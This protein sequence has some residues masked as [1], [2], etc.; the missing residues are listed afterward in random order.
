[1][2]APSA[3]ARAALAA[4]LLAGPALAGLAGVPLPATSS[5]W[6]ADPAR[7]VEG[8]GDVPVMPGLAPAE[9]APLVFDK[10]A[11]R[12]AQSVMAG[13]M[14]RNAVLSFYNQTMP[15]LGWSRAPQR[16]GGSA[17]FLREGEELRLEFVEPARAAAQKAAATIVRF[18]LIPR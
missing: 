15:Q 2:T 14:D 18:S 12:I 17:S 3:T 6:A 11:G 4:L 9:E 1:M 5:A 8:M 16:A 13:A 7:Y 10:P